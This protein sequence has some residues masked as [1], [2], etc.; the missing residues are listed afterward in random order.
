MEQLLEDSPSFGGSSA[1]ALKYPTVTVYGSPSSWLSQS[2]LVSMAS[3]SDDISCDDTS[4]SLGD[5]TYEFIDDKST[6]VSDD[7][8][9]GSSAVFSTDGRD[10]EPKINHGL[11][12]RD[13]TSEQ[14]SQSSYAEPS[15]IC[16]DLDSSLATISTSNYVETDQNGHG[17]RSTGCRDTLE[18]NNQE[19][20]HTIVLVESTIKSA[21]PAVEAEGSYTTRVWSADESPD[22]SR[23]SPQSPPP[24]QFTVT[25]KQTMVSHGLVLSQPYKVLYIGDNSARDQVIQKIG[26]ALAVTLESEK[27]RP[28]RF[29]IV[30]ISSFG[31]SASP[32]VVLIDSTGLEL[33]VEECHSASFAKLEGW[34]D[35]ISMALSDRTLVESFWSG[36]KLTVTGHWKLPD[37]AI[38]YLSENDNFSMKQTRRFA[39]SFMNRH[40]VPCIFI[41]QT[42]CLNYSSQD[43]IALD[44]K[45]PHLCLQAVGSDVTKSETIKRIP[46]DLQSFLSLDCRQVNRSLA[47]LA[48]IYRTGYSKPESLDP[49]CS[50]LT[51]A[52]RNSKD[53][54][55]A[56]ERISTV[57]KML[58]YGLLLVLGFL[59]YQLAIFNVFNAPQTYRQ[60]TKDAAAVPTIILT[61]LTNVHL[62]STRTDLA[63]SPVLTSSS[64]NQYPT[65]RS[66]SAQANTEIASFLQDGQGLVPNNSDKFKISVLGDSHILL[67]PPQWFLRSRKAPKLSFCVSRGTHTLNHQVSTPFDGVFTI[68]IPRD[69]AYGLLNVSIWTT[70]KPKIEVSFEVE[71]GSSCWWGRLGH[72]VIGILRKET[73]VVNTGLTTIS[74]QTTN[75]FRLMMGWVNREASK[76]LNTAEN[77]GTA[78]LDQTARATDLV[79]DRTRSISRSLSRL[80]HGNL[81]TS[82]QLLLYA[83]YL[84]PSHIACRINFTGFKGTTLNYKNKHLRSTQKRA[85]KLWWGIRGVPKQDLVKG[86]I[87]PKTRISACTKRMSR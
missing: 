64:R 73:A 72:A 74:N 35:T 29:N 32:E 61:R 15:N 62:V 82:K 51:R 45:T 40:F 39:R 66:G 49:S 19:G 3:N 36:S 86:G 56:T 44:P 26:S 21:G 20:E 14:G 34:N 80:S 77:I 1:I 52:E 57:E 63:K 30:P 10:I 65:P 28:S 46:I 59:L 60:N 68:E 23:Q 87:E 47:C 83:K 84:H 78:S 43:I 37:I 16:F 81:M 69:D 55:R 85:L 33:S 12:R 27:A 41:S 8:E 24:A 17:T 76:I 54:Y 79:L 6:V 70:A 50:P 75:D 9:Q 5:S 38:F 48:T 67:R 11:L 4:S 18:P 13:S 25:I 7:E 2:Q 31:D 42:P 53:S 71:F 58:K 22:V